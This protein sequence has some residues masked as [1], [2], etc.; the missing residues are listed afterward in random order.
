MKK[1]LLK[2]ELN[3]IYI[4]KDDNGRIT[5]RSMWKEGIV[6]SFFE[7]NVF[8]T[9]KGEKELKRVGLSDIAIDGDWKYNFYNNGEY[10]TNKELI[11]GN[12]YRFTTADDTDGIDDIK[13]YTYFF[14]NCGIPSHMNLSYYARLNRYDNMYYKD[15]INISNLNDEKYKY[16]PMTQEEIDTFNNLS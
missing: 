5:K 9:F 6:H 14:H 10:I 1:S 3:I 2:R 4:P 12:Y 15:T 11:Y 7:D 8:V 16:Y 13:D